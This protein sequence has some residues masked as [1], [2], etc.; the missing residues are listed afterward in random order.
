MPPESR[1]RDALQLVLTAWKDGKTAKQ[2][3]ETKPVISAFDARWRAGDKLE[4]FQIESVQAEAGKPVWFNVSLKMKAPS[5]L[6]KAKYVVIG[7][8]PIMV[9]REEDYNKLSGM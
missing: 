7:I 9:Y 3:G 4:D 5:K 8:D 2:I 1:S 6:V